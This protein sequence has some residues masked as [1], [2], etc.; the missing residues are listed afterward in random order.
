MM[1]TLM[2]LGFSGYDVKPGICVFQCQYLLQNPLFLWEKILVAL[3]TKHRCEKNEPIL[4]RFF[5][6]GGCTVSL[7]GSYPKCVN[8]LTLKST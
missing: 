3:N 1:S 8:K 6:G 4:D 7:A 5:F 2:K